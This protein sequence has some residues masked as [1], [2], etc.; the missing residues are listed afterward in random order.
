MT[1]ERDITSVHVVT[2]RAHGVVFAGTKCVH[3][4]PFGD[5]CG[6]DKATFHV[7]LD[8]WD[9]VDSRDLPASTTVS[10]V[11]D[12]GGKFVDAS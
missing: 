1:H 4:C 12:A 2:V 11:L 7:S 9:R 6:H 5:D 8:S 3:D 10:D